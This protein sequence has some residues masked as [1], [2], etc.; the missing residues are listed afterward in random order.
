MFTPWGCPHV[1]AIASEQ[2]ILA[3]YFDE[4][5]GRSDWER[6]HALIDPRCAGLAQLIREYNESLPR[7]SD[8]RLADPEH[9][10][11]IPCFETLALS[12]PVVGRACR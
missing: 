8:A 1:P 2:S 5:P 10:L 11:V 3:T 7:G 12:A 6:I 4:V 9:M